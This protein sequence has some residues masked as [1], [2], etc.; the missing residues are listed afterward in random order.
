MNYFERYNSISPQLTSEAIPNTLTIIVIPAFNEPD[1]CTPLRSLADQNFSKTEVILVINHSESS[2]PAI[3]EQS[4]RSINEV[5]EFK[6]SNP[7]IADRIHVLNAVD[8]PKK[9]AGVGLARKIGMDEASWRFDQMQQNGLIVCLDADSTVATNY[10]EEINKIAEDTSISGCSIYYEHPLDGPNSEP[11]ILYELFLRYYNIAQEHCGL[12]YSFHTVGSSMAVRSKEYQKQ[13][14]MNR[15][16]AGEDFYFL[17]KIIPQPTFIN[18][19]TTCVYPSDR[20][21]DRVPFG[22]G[23]S[24]LNH[25]DE[26][27]DLLVSYDPR[28]FELVKLFVESVMQAYPNLPIID[29][30]FPSVFM[31]WLSTEKFDKKHAE[32]IRNSTNRTNFEKRFFTWFDAFKVLKLMH[33]LRDQLYPNVDIR[34]GIKDITNQSHLTYKELLLNLRVREKS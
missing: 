12:P 8:L 14:G 11:I 13:G 20:T 27:Q 34:I 1:V 23:R 7:K 17:H 32:S 16:K 9:H 2:T 10:I 31:D 26:S 3:K 19:T 18:L 29:N 25:Y 22:T 15:R 24:M 4:V 33:F 21:S 28:S 30:Q 5:I 6:R